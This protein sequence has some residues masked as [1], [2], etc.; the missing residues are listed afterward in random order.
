[1]IYLNLDVGLMQAMGRR[2]LERGER[3]WFGC[4]TVQQV[5]RD[6]G[7]WDS[8]LYDYRGLRDLPFDLD[9]AAR[10]QYGATRMTHAMLFT[11]VD[12]SEGRPRRWRVESSHGEAWG[13]RGFGT[14]N[15]S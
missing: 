10:L 7:L 12:I 15:D 8:R 6:L 5:R 11:G 4:D 1:M 14:M 2:L 9:P 13:Q 3:V